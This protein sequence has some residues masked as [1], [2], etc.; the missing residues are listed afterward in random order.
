MNVV[1][2]S[3]YVP[4]PSRTGGHRRVAALLRALAGFAQVHVM[5]IGDPALDYTEA[6]RQLA[7]A[8]GGTLE[9]FGPA[10]PEPWSP[11]TR[12]AVDRLPDAAPHFWSPPLL[13]ALERRLAA[14]PPDVLHVEELV[15]APYATNAAVP[16]ILSRQKVECVFHESAAALGLG[17][18]AWQRAEAERFRRW[19]ARV[20]PYFDAAFVPGAGDVAALAPWHSADRVHVVPI[21]VED[22][23]V[24]PAD[25]T[26]AVRQVVIYGTLDYLPNI[27]AYGR[28]FRE[29]WPRVRAE[30]AELVTV[31][32]GSGEVP[33]CI[34]RDDAR[35]L[36][37]GFV[38]D[39]ASV[40]QGPGALVVPL[41]IGGGARTKI[42]EAMAC[43]MPVVSTA[44]GA[45][46]IG[47]VDG[48]HY[49]AAETPDAF[50][51][52][53]L[54]LAGD[55]A[56]AE[57]L[58]RNA[59]AHVDAGFR[60]AAV[61]ASARPVFRALAAQARSIGRV[62]APPAPTSAAAGLRGVVERMARWL[63]SS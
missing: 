4:F 29:V 33:S 46:N 15:M 37:R 6:R 26:A 16:R 3:P 50:V 60:L 44:L 23:F 14:S 53:I 8:C 43:G 52:A 28:Y 5:A 20:A 18:A 48:R 45:E 35:V 21:V 61:E 63:R 7:D 32:V 51:S 19:E 54:D 40:L 36:V 2:L 47:A 42:L 31:V 62:G 10:G 55:P 41:R 56:R 22:A 39:V 49:R 1:F 58:G 9:V 38:E 12:Y 57:A 27:D 17:D 13:E 11:L 24:R 34:P 25:R 59:A 30:H